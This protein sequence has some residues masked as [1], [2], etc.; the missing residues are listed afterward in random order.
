MAIGRKSTATT[1]AGCPAPR[2]ALPPCR[3]PAVSPRRARRAAAARS[4]TRRRG[5]RGAHAARY[6]TRRASHRAAALCSRERGPARAARGRA[7]ARAAEAVAP[8]DRGVER[9]VKRNR[10]ATADVAVQ[11]RHD[12]RQRQARELRIAA[13]AVDQDVLRGAGRVLLHASLEGVCKLDAAIAHRNRA[14]REQA[15]ARRVE[16]AGLAIDHNPARIRERR[17]AKPAHRPRLKSRSRGAGALAPRS[18]GGTPPSECAGR[19]R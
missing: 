16:S 7:R 5:H 9:C 12:L 11:F 10:N 2:A 18:P 1:S 19:C 13:D 8:Q 15:I 17:A 3:C 14:D 6:R 4:R